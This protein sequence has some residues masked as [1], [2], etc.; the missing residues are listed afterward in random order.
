M[1]FQVTKKSFLGSGIALIVIAALFVAA[2]IV[3]GY[4]KA[5][6]VTVSDYLAISAIIFLTGTFVIFDLTTDALTDPTTSLYRLAQIGT[7]S[8]LIAGASTWT[9][10][11][12][13]LFL[14]IQLFGVKTWVRLTSYAV[15]IVTFL[16]LLGWNAYVAATCSPLGRDN[17][18]EVVTNCSSVTARGGLIVGVIGVVTDIIILVL[19]LPIIL[20]LNLP[21][22]K[23]IGIVGV[24]LTGIFA[25][26]A[27]ATSLYFRWASSS[28]LP[29]DY[30]AATTWTIIELSI[31]IM[32]GCVPAAYAAWVSYAVN[33]ALFSRLSALVSLLSVNR[34]V[35]SKTSQE[36]SRSGPSAGDSNRDGP[37]T[38]YTHH[39]YGV[40]VESNATKK[41]QTSATFHDVDQISLEEMRKGSNP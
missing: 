30:R 25:L 3:G 28:G 23:R 4:K 26:A 20:K 8:T 32:V 27:S 38:E 2:R 1:A 36:W 40:I 29:V 11:S 5:R 17:L 39:P 35:R 15:L 19:P 6:K 13:I 14:Y 34:S 22:G 16:F 24:F 31:A 7:A 12:P 9:A 33:S 10:K 21:F 37:S 18:V 41:G